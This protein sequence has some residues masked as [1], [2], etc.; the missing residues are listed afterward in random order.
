M[1]HPVR[2]AMTFLFTDIVGSTRMWQED[3]TAMRLA[4]QVHD[5]LAAEA[6]HGHEGHIVKHTGDGVFAVFAE[7]VRAALAAIQFQTALDAA[8]WPTATPLRIRAV[9]LH[10]AAELRDGD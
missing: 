3:E 1:G 8:A 5:T 9:M 7:P 2:R 6:I 10:G 4:V